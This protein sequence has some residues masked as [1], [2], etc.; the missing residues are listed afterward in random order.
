M[1]KR[2]GHGPHPITP[3]LRAAVFS[4]WDHR[5]AY[6]EV[7]AAEHVDHIFPR[8]KGGLDHVENYTAA[9]QPCNLAKSDLELAQGFLEIL[10][11]RARQKAPRILA[12]IER[13][14]RQ[15]PHPRRV[16]TTTV[17]MAQPLHVI[18]YLLALERLARPTP[19]WLVSEFNNRLSPAAPDLL[20][21][22]SQ[23]TTPHLVEA[24]GHDR[25]KWSS[26]RGGGS[27]VRQSDSDIHSGYCRFR[28]H[29]KFFQAL[30]LSLALKASC[31]TYVGSTMPT[32]PDVCCAERDST[33]PPGL[34]SFPVDEFRQQVLPSL[35]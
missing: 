28:V 27:F 14:K 33:Q 29:R 9:C 1:S 21:D 25:S 4:A 34:V 24:L 30:R 26:Y 7:R 20:L 8:A 3:E 16:E 23:T 11:A 2:A 6:C 15:K 18:P 12:D 35:A 13:R 32:D 5:C 10:A 19:T 31:F 22:V 17:S